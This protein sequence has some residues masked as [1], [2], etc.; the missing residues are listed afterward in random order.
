MGAKSNPYP[1]IKNAD[2]MVVT[3]IYESQPMVMLE[4]LTLGVPV[5]S[6]Q[7]TSAFEILENKPYGILCDN[8]VEGIADALNNN[9]NSKALTGLREGCK[10]F[11]YNNAEIISKV[12]GL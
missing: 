1:L 7:F 8:S 11:C 10:A 4:A 12:L 2:V 6:T 9:L 3:S 5:I